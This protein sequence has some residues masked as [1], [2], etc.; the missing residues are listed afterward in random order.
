MSATARVQ[1]LRPVAR[2]KLLLL[3]TPAAPQHWL[4]VTASSGV[5]LL[6]TD[7]RGHKLGLN[8]ATS[9]E[10]EEIPGGF[11]DQDTVD[12]ADDPHPGPPQACPATALSVP[13]PLAGRYVLTATACDDGDYDLLVSADEVSGKRFDASF[14]G[15]HIG[16][17][18]VHRYAVDYSGEVKTESRASRAND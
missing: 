11:I 10:A 1:T 12:D 6:M 3:K 9:T 15:V 8:P 16:K 17:G 7:P 4:H 5:Q 2:Q 13:A 14:R 18:E